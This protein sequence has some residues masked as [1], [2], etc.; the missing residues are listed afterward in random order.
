MIVL[1]L[2][3]R[4]LLRLRI[5]QENSTMDGLPMANLNKLLNILRVGLRDFKSKDLKLKSLNIKVILH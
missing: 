5:F 1:S 3:S 4:N 2:N